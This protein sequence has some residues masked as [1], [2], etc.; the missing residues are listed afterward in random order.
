MSVK[1]LTA[2]EL[3]DR[4]GGRISA[5][6]LSNWRWAGTGPKFLKLG[7]RVVYPLRDLE[8]WEARRTVVSTSEYCR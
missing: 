3:S 7:G 1:F 2:Q 5:R 8:A 4:Y 6:T